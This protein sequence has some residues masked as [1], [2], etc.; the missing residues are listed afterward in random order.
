M[1][2]AKIHNFYV[3]A[4]Y[5]CTK[6]IFNYIYLIYLGIIDNFSY[7]CLQNEARKKT[8]L[9]ESEAIG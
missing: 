5:L 7:L 4:K 8:I 9:W 3:P 1:S 2:A 6:S